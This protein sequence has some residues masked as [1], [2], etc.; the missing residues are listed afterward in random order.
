MMEKRLV[1]KLSCFFSRVLRVGMV[2][3]VLPHCFDKLRWGVSEAT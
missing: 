1:E 3:L 2:K